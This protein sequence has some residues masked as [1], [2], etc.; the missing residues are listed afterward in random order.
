MEPLTV[1]QHSESLKTLL[2]PSFSCPRQ[3][4]AMFSVRYGLLKQQGEC[5]IFGGG[6]AGAPAALCGSKCW[7]CL[8]CFQ[9]DPKLR[10]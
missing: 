5:V 7:S 1:S 9:L 6:A 8:K 4:P 10:L 2:L 3:S